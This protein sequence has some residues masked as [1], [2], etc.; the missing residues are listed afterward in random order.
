MDTKKGG[1][2]HFS[3]D[4]KEFFFT[5]FESVERIFLF[6]TF[7]FQLEGRK[8]EYLIYFWIGRGNFYFQ[9]ISEMA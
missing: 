7:F 1:F 2:R 5:P 8:F 4:E 6:L 3:S 9:F